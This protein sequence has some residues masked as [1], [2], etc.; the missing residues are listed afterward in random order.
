LVRTAD[1]RTLREQVTAWEQSRH[2]AYQV[3]GFTGVMARLVDRAVGEWTF[4]GRDSRSTF[5][6]TYTFS[7]TSAAT[8]PFVWLF[9]RTMWSGYMR[10][11]ADRCVE[12][13]EAN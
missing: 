1:H 11:C 3:D 5:T 9:V 8:T 12:L 2:F 13:A 6:W 7:A 10:R 4:S